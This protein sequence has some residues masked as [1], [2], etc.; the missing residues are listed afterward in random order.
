MKCNDKASRIVSIEEIGTNALF[1]IVH[2]IVLDANGYLQNGTFYGHV[3]EERN[4]EILPPIITLN[5]VA[6]YEKIAEEKILQHL[7]LTDFLVKDKVDENQGYRTRMIKAFLT[8]AKEQKFPIIKGWL[9]PIDLENAARLHHFYVEKFGFQ[10]D[11]NHH[12][13]LQIIE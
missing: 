6:S 4:A 1:V 3:V 5:Y 2:Q 7:F 13:S 12:I 11:E 8:F 10:I 9:S